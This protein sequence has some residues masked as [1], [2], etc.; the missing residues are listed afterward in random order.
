ME[1]FE[2]GE[3]RLIRIGNGEGRGRK[4]DSVGLFAVLK[5]CKTRLLRK[6]LQN[7]S[8]MEPI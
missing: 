6:S 2:V 5:T 1:W 8:D 3:R 7:K 4:L